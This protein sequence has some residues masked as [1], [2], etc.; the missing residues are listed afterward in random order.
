MLKF[1]AHRNLWLGLA[2]AAVLTGGFLFLGHYRATH[3]ATAQAKKANA[4]KAVTAKGATAK[5]VAAKS[6]VAK[7][8]PE[9]TT[10]VTVPK[11]TAISATVSQTLATDKNK[12]GDTFAASLTAPIEIE[13]QTVIPKGA[14]VTGRVV[15]IKKH[16]IKVTLASVVVH[17]QSYDLETNSLSGS[18]AKVDDTATTKNVKSTDQAP[19]NKDVTLLTAKS[20]LTF[21][22]SKPVIIPVKG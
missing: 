13:G 19:V 21:K 15:K 1:Q 8:A 14:K 22:L 18:K 16:E 2:A 20:Q 3:Q 6:V 4:G 17:G 11:G 7:K 5:P 10:M 9:P 12:V